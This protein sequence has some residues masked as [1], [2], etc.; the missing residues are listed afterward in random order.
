MKQSII[1]QVRIMAKWLNLQFLK[2][3]KLLEQSEIDYGIKS[4]DPKF[5]LCLHSISHLKMLNP[6]C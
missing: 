4:G 2:K 6:T 1:Y 3:F 5:D